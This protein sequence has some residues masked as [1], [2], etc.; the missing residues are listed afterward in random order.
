MTEQLN[1]T[2]YCVTC[3]SPVFKTYKDDTNTQFYNCSNCGII[4]KIQ[5][6]TVASQQEKTLKDKSS[7]NNFIENPFNTIYDVT[8]QTP[9]EQ[10]NA[11]E[12]VKNLKQRLQEEYNQTQALKKAVEEFSRNPNVEELLMKQA[13]TTISSYDD[14]IIRVVFHVGLSAYHKPLNLGLK[15]ESGSGKSYSTVETIKFLPEE[16]VQVIGSQSPKVISH[17]NGIRKTIDGRELKEESIP[18]K[19]KVNNYPDKQEF[20][21]A[22]KVYK[23]QKVQWENDCKNSFYEVDLRN[24]ILLFLESVNPETFK[25]LKTTMSHDHAY[26]DHKYVDDKGKVHV[27]RL[28][29]APVMIFN[30]VDN[31]YVA[32]Q[33]TRTLT[34]TPSARVEKIEDSMAISN[35]KSAYPWLYEAE[36]F[37]RRVITEY[38]RKVKQFMAAGKVSV[39]IPFLDIYEGFSKEAVRDMRDFNK[40]LELLPSYAIFKLFQRPIAM[41][42]GKRYLIPTVQDAMD[43]KDAFDAI[44]ETTKTSTDYRV[45]DFYKSTIVDT[46]GLTAEQITDCYNKGKKRQ[47]AV[48]TVRKWLNRLEEIDFVDVREDVTDRRCKLYYPLKKNM[49]FVPFF[50]KSESLRSILEIGFKKWVKSVSFQTGVPLIILNIDG[51]AKSISE[52]ELEKIVLGTANF[53]EI[54]FVSKSSFEALNK[55]ENMLFSGNNLKG[56]TLNDVFKNQTST[57]FGGVLQRN[58]VSYVE[59]N[60]NQR[61]Q[62]L[63]NEVDTGGDKLVLSNSGVKCVAQ[64]SVGVNSFLSDVKNVESDNSMAK[65]EVLIDHFEC[66]RQNLLEAVVKTPD[67]AGFASLVECVEVRS[68]DAGVPCACCS[69]EGTCNCVA[70]FLDGS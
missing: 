36:P 43:A 54:D 26:I 27:T 18:E 33:A 37:Q 12:E 2:F 48:K 38:V 45:L 70:Y 40:Y 60:I 34:A 65:Q 58:L 66:D 39:A 59:A 47:T 5:N 14:H 30:S 53:E 31:E 4:T 69:E 42:E 11:Q 15:A 52:F 23:Q 62:N 35:N 22:L 28:V 63:K 68:G 46:T 44:L 61:D 17:E 13:H 10:E 56:T 67:F 50:E 9:V 57:A 1:T 24:K 55:P 7:K 25:M 20:N 49:P 32:E 21:E 64:G 41:I 19:P 29:G 16:D 8:N 6:D 51:T 3:H